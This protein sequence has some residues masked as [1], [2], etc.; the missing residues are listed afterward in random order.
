[1]MRKICICGA[2]M[3]GVNI[4]DGQ[5]VKTRNLYKELQN[6]FSP[7]SVF[8]VDSQTNKL[9]LLLRVL[10]YYLKCDVFIMLPAHNGLMMFTPLLYYLNKIVKRRLIYSV[11]GGWLPSTLETADGLKRKLM[12]FDS[13]LVET[14]TMKAKLEA[15]GFSNVTVMPNFKNLPLLDKSELVVNESAPFKLI[16]FSR[17][18]KQK[19]I[20]D[21]INV[22]KRINEECGKRMYELDIYGSV[23]S[24]EARWFDEIK[25]SLPEY[26]SY[27]GVAKPQESVEIVKSYF[28]LLFPTRFYTEGIPGTIIDAYA[29]GVPVISAKWESFTDVV[30]EGETGF[31]YEFEDVEGFYRILNKVKDEPSMLNS[32]KEKCL[33]KANEFTPGHAMSKLMI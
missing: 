33:L 12:T 29:A 26:V 6:K 1:M 11:I 31:G 21:A 19:G 2:F 14:N 13:I 22:V 18:M 3:N 28:A 16:T 9:L 24:N 25:A 7:E 8:S 32:L 30:D 20:E 10:H 4:A 17:V 15:L 23:D 27:K 5:S